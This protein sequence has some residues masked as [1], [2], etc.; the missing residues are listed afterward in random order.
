MS[1]LAGAPLSAASSHLLKSDESSDVTLS[2][3]RGTAYMVK[4]AGTARGP[5]SVSAAAGTTCCVITT[6]DRSDVG[7]FSLNHFGNRTVK[8]AVTRFGVK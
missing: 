3:K 2:E 7:F 4:V 5:V 8:L 1:F 6:G